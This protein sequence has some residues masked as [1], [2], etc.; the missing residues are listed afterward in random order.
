[1]S[2]THTLSHASTAQIV[3]GLARWLSAL[4]LALAITLAIFVFMR[5]LIH[6][7]A[8]QI[9]TPDET[10]RIEIAEYVPDAEPQPR[11]PP[12]RVETL[13]PP[14]SPQ[15]VTERAD[16]PAEEGALNYMPSTVTPAVE[17]TAVT[18]Q[19]IAPSPITFRTPPVYP[20]R[21]QT[22]GITGSCTIRYDILASG[23]TANLEVTQC[24]SSGFARAS[25]AAVQQWRH[26][27][28]R[29]RASDEIVSRGVTTTLV[30]DLEE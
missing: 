12:E 10:P 8:V 18:G 15:I 5:L 24:D 28:Y 19:L 6:V 14:A 20:S 13:P 9:I 21:E 26:Q 7:D 29:D 4:F 25:L 1:M 17:L 30:F 16:L 22:R 3:G 23:Q 27:A 2:E 11:T